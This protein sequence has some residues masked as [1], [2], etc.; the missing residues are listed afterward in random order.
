MYLIIRLLQ[1]TLRNKDSV[2]IISFKIR[3]SMIYLKTNAGKIRSW[4]KTG[5]LCRMGGGGQ[6][7]CKYG[8]SSLTFW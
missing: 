1:H 7:S 6:N 5:Y 2:S 4:L 8:K 3:R